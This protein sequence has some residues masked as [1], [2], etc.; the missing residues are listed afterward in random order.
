MRVEILGVDIGHACPPHDAGVV[1]EDVDSAE[2]CD[3]GRDEGAGAV[4]R[5]DVVRV[6]HGPTAGA[7]DLVDDGGGRSGVTTHASNRSTDVVDG[8]A[9]ATRREQ[10]RVRT[11]DAASRA[12][13]DGDA[14][15]EPELGQA[16]TAD[17]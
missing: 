2:L 11:P 4:D 10:Q 9:G 14:P 12:G 7:D 15:V 5:R 6:G 17:V 13:D 3:R 16:A 1:D 8:D